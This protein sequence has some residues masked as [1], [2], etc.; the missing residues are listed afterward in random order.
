MH[1]DAAA[2]IDAAYKAQNG[3]ATF[4]VTAALRDVKVF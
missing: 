1:S 4:W 3:S 2:K